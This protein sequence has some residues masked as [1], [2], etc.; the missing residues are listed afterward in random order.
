MAVTRRTPSTGTPTIDGAAVP[1]YDRVSA[2]RLQASATG[3][4]EGTSYD[5][6]GSELVGTTALIRSG[7]SLSGMTDQNRERALLAASE[8]YARE[9][10]L[11]AEGTSAIRDYWDSTGRWPDFSGGAGN[12]SGAVTKP[13]G[14]AVS[15]TGQSGSWIWIVAIAGGLA[16]LLL[17]MPHSKRR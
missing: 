17:L 4:A 13:P 7:A 9:A 14:A 5:S 12:A 6:A 3:T 1:W 11:G 10:G 15:A 2:D 16:L 8:A